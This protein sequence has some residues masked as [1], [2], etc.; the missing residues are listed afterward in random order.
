[1]TATTT[2]GPADQIAVIDRG[3]VIAHGT[4]AELKGLT[5]ADTLDEVFLSLTGRPIEEPAEDDDL[6]EISA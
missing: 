6:E 5:G 3:R 1:M 2:A 4:S